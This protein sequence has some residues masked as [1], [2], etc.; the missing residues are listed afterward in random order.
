[1]EYGFRYIIIRSP[2]TLDSIY[3]RRTIPRPTA[4]IPTLSQSKAMLKVFV[5]EGGNVWKVQKACPCDS[6]FF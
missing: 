6:D 4:V 1:M 5:A 2:Y 3:L